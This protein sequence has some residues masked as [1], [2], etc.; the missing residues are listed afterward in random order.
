LNSGEVTDAAGWTGVA[1]TS[2]S[3]EA[4]NLELLVQ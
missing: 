4:R 1:G 2:L 3:S